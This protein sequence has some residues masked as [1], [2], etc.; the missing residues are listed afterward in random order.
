MD[1]SAWTKEDLMKIFHNADN[2]IFLSDPARDRFVEINRTVLSKLDYKRE[3]ILNIPP[4]EFLGPYST[5]KKEEIHFRKDGRELPAEVTSYPL[6]LSD[7]HTYMLTIAT[8]ISKN[9]EMK[10]R[11]K[12]KD[13]QFKSLFLYNPDTIFSLD[14]NGRYTNINHAGEELFGYP[15]EEIKGTPYLHFL[16]E[17]AGKKTLD[18]FRAVTAGQTVRFDTIIISKDGGHHIMDV[19]A[20]PVIIE[21]VITGVIGIAR[22]ITL[23]A[24][25]E[26][27]LSESEQRY[28]SLFENNIDAV[29]TFD[30]EGRFTH[31]N[32]ST[33]RVTGVSGE[34][35]IGR[36]FLPLIIPNMREK[37]MRQFAVSLEGTPNEYETSIFNVEGE[38]LDLYIS[39]LPIYVDGDI[40]GIHCIA[41]NITAQKKL[42][43]TMNHFAYHDTLTG[44]PNQRHFHEEMEKT[45]SETK[46]SDTQFSL[47]FLDLDRFKFI[48]DYLGHHMGDELLK[49][50]ATRLKHKLEERATLFRYGGDEFLILT[51]QVT[52]EETKG[53]AEDVIEEM[54]KS[55]DLSGFDAVVT[56]SIGVSMYPEHGTEADSLIRRAD[57]AMYHA[58]N[59]GKNT[60]QVY[61]THIQKEKTNL[62]IES[63]LYKALKNGEFF[64]SYQPQFET[65]EENISG[66]EVLIRWDN[67][68]LGIVS[69]G[70]FI[71]IAEETGLIVPI[72]EWVI[73]EA[74]RRNK[75]WLDAGY[76]AMSVSVNLSMRQFYHKELVEMIAEIL[77][78]TGLPPEF[79]ELEITESMA[80]HAEQASVILTELNKLGVKISIDDFGTGYSSLSYLK[81]FPIDQLKIDQSFVRDIDSNKEDNDIIRTI[82]SLAHNLNLEVIAEGV[83]TKAQLEFLKRNGCFKFQGYYLAKPMKPEEVTELF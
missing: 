79:L 8:D 74:C 62:K 7:G 65:N 18:H 77:Y 1:A 80:I 30:L 15:A 71:P 48:N 50:V 43:E 54:E 81:R 20:V 23:K 49:Q 35:L 76:P 34:E 36:S 12:Y 13:Q 58:K 21:N 56:V 51:R 14:M 44:L 70:E 60:Y 45:L 28:R 39:L 78:E 66:V 55:F 19:T 57:N 61:N 24:Q 2:G 63:L 3:E 10:Y 38:Q 73:R 64:L 67:K 40:T 25:T 32:N 5:E 17:E 42:E 33:I 52:K 9:R 4:S 16:P 82:I 11:L 72:G 68:E 22:D 31:V 83:K 6:T 26:Q 47:F 41:K 69:P 29:M 75:A 46:N 37:T 27:R 59:L 53:I